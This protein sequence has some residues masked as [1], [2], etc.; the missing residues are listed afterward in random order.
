MKKLFI[1]SAC[2]GRNKALMHMVATYSDR[3]VLVGAEDPSVTEDTLLSE[4]GHTIPLYGSF[5]KVPL[6]ECE[7]DVVIGCL[8]AERAKAYA[9]QCEAMDQHFL[10]L[11]VL[12]P[13]KEDELN[14][15]KTWKV[16]FYKNGNILGIDQR[17]GMELLRDVLAL[18]ES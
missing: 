11:G 2:S 10:L 6:A 7:P 4:N 14:K 18:E 16:S 1:V 9:R 3:Y 8:P 5:D 15:Q 13:K 17:R 12:P